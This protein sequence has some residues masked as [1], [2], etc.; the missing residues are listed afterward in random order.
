M[1]NILKVLA[2]IFLSISIVACG[3]TKKKDSEDELGIANG[4]LKDKG[5]REENN[6]PAQSFAD[7]CK[8]LQGWQPIATMCQYPKTTITVKYPDNFSGIFSKS[9][10]A[11]RRGWIVHAI[12]DA[13]GAANLYI[14]A[15]NGVN[16][17]LFPITN[18]DKSARANI[19]GQILMLVAPTKF[20]TDS[21]I[22]IFE[23]VSDQKIFTMCPF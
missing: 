10:I 20:S 12:G 11:L 5:N 14:M 16:T 2:F 1:Q 7:Y 3:A 21:V 17:P 22:S 6:G 15:E 13:N 18:M 8:G 4:K 9:V 19:D 23:C